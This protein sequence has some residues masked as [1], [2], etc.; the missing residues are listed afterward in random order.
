MFFFFFFQ[1][2]RRERKYVGKD[3]KTVNVHLK[4]SL[5]AGVKNNN[6]STLTWRSFV[7][8]FEI[9][10]LYGRWR[11]FVWPLKIVCMAVG[12]RLYGR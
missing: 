3:A 12:D 10:R 5:G 4:L 9:D 2:C 6:L 8:P 11:S 7:W 1:L